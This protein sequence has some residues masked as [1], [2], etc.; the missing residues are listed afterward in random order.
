MPDVI[1]MDWQVG[2]R[3]DFEV[4]EYVPPVRTVPSP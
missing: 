1:C 2:L 4:V 3:P